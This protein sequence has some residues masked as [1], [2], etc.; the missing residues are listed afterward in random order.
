[1]KEYDKLKKKFNE[2]KEVFETNERTYIKMKNT[3][4]ELKKKYKGLET[5]IIIS[6]NNMKIVLYILMNSLKIN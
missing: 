5:D 1:M 4:K 2:L 3:N 6:K